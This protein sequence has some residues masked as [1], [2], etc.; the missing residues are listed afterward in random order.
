MV[1]MWNVNYHLLISKIKLLD[2]EG[3]QSLIT[4]T[5]MLDLTFILQMASWRACWTGTQ[6]N[7]LSRLWM[8][9]HQV[10]WFRR[11]FNHR[12][13]SYVVHTCKLFFFSVWPSLSILNIFT[14]NTHV[15]H[16]YVYIQT[17]LYNFNTLTI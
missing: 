4:I 14:L 5:S 10:L 2:F 15:H 1:N 16:V 11:Y 12:N 7:I 9:L 3:V 17:F 13:Y 8:I 6:R